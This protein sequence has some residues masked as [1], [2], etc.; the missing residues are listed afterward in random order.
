MPGTAKQWR[1]FTNM[2][3][4][5]TVLA[6]YCPDSSAQ[7]FK[8][9]INSKVREDT[10]YVSDHTHDLTV[11]V[12][13]S[14]KYTSYSLDDHYLNKKVQYRPNEPFNVGFGF[15]YKLLGIN[16]A[17]NLPFI[18]STD[19]R[20]KT[21]FLDLQTHLYLRKMTVDFY[22]QFYRGYYID[23]PE[24]IFPNWSD[25]NKTPVR[26]DIRTRN[27]GVDYHY[28]FNDR[29]FSFRAAYLQNEYQKKS[30]GSFLLGGNFMYVSIRADSSLIPGNLTDPRFFNGFDFDRTWIL[31]ATVSAGY[32]HTFVFRKHF[33]VT[34]ALQGGLGLNYTIL[35]S[36]ANVEQQSKL[37][38]QL[39]TTL[40]IA[41]GYNTDY[42]YAGFHYVDFIG[43]SHSPEPGSW[44]NFGSGMFRLT[45]AKRFK[46]RK[47]IF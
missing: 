19:Q 32:A 39:N 15:N 9:I 14:R 11:R 2:L 35:R 30:A 29:K 40:R 37:G 4:L 25:N 46:L 6:G 42:Y 22:G 45:V 20:G 47:P 27:I 24:R 16:I 12:F 34:G 5:L 28:I 1:C 41:A 10:S 17:L 38:G 18:N 3:F 44:Q 23:N 21:S 8:K 33:F 43:R 13:G 36:E 31:Y 7:P 26:P